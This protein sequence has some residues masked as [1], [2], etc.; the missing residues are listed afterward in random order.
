MDDWDPPDVDLDINAGGNPRSRMLTEGM[1]RVRTVE[2]A[3]RVLRATVPFSVRERV[4]SGN[5]RREDMAA[6][7]RARLEL[8]FGTERHSLRALLGADAPSWASP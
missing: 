4:R 3:R 1:R 7:D 6:D 8:V 2:P 5:I